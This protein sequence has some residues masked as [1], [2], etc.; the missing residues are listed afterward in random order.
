M[1]DAKSVGGGKRGRHHRW[2][3]IPKERMTDVVARRFVTAE[4]IMLAQVFLKKGA[5][6]QRHTHESEQVTYI[7][8]GALRLW[9]GNEGAEEEFTVRA[10]EVLTIPSNVPHRAE[11]LEDTLDVDVFSPP[12]QDWLAGTDAYLR[13]GPSR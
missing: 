3:D 11:A 10:G 1:S 13:E 5:V 6:V 7:V 4:R 9:L 8:E 2:E 12:R